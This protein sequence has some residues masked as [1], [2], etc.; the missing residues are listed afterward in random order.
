MR[1][2]SAIAARVAVAC[3]AG[4]VFRG[5]LI[6]LCLA[7]SGCEQPK[8]EYTEVKRLHERVTDA[9]WKAFVRVVDHLQ[10]RQ[11]PS[12]PKVFPPP[13]QW[14]EGRTALVTDLCKE[15]LQRREECWDTARLALVFRRHKP[16]MR[17]LQRER[18]TAEQFAG[19]VLTI[20]A[21]MC[22]S[23][24]PANIDLVQLADRSRRLVEELKNNHQQAFTT[25]SP[26]TRFAVVLQAMW[27]PRLVRAEKL[28]QVPPENLSLVHRHLAWLEHAFPAEFLENPPEELR[29]LYEERG[30]PFDE[31][32][33]SGSDEDLD[34]QV[35]RNLAP[36]R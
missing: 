28:Q 25:L 34:A 21:A 5:G 29:D 13:P 16:L 9:E 35:V 26:E 11:L 14:Q 20:G 32:P 8:Q 17:L 33:D 18:M 19:L 23:D 22:R 24:V 10:D 12:F 36:A 2:L 15:E 1:R 27:I 7:V 6:G 4:L 3:T 31:M 30:L